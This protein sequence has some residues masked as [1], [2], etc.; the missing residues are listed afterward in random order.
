VHGLLL[1]KLESTD[2][3]TYV[4]PCCSSQEIFLVDN[5]VEKLKL[6]N[7]KVIGVLK[8]IYTEYNEGDSDTESIGCTDSTDETTNR[9][10][11]E[12]E[13]RNIAI[14][15]MKKNRFVVVVAFNKSSCTKKRNK[16]RC[17]T[18]FFFFMAT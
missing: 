16:C 2:R 8:E 1:S 15:C 12:T 6:K 13:Q 14:K 5:F 3:K 18:I 4:C 9:I 10:F 7:D 17:V 11:T